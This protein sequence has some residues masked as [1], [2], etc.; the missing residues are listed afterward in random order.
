LPC[1][2]CSE[3]VGGKVRRWVFLHYFKPGQPTLN[4]LDPSCAAQ[5]V[6]SGDVTRTIHDLG[7]RVVRLDAVPFLGIEREPGKTLS[8]HFKHPLSVV[9]TDHVAMLTRKLGGW[10]FH[11]LNVPLEDLKKFTKD[12]PDLSYD[13]FTRAQVLHALLSGDAAPLRQAYGFLLDA[14]VDP[15]TLVH[16][17]QNHD[18]ITYQ[19]VELDHRKDET[20]TL[21]GKKATGKE[22]REGMLRLMRERAAGAAAP[23]NKLYRPEKDGVATTFPGFI[24]AA[25]EVRDPYNASDEEVERIKRGHLLLAVANAMQPGVFSLSSWDLVGALPVPEEDVSQWAKQGDHRW[26]NRGGVDLLGADLEAKKSALGLP[27][28][29][30]L[31]G[32]IPRQIEDA[33]SFVSQLA[34]LLAAR[35][36]FRIAEG[37]LLAAPEVKNQGVCVLVMKLP[38]RGVAVTGLN[39]GRSEVTESVELKAGEDGKRSGWVF[40][41]VLSGRD[42]GKADDEG[43]LKMTLPPLAGVTW[44]G[45]PN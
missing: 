38:D 43:R 34:R 25:M 32:P 30:A 2:D 27:R 8:K 28:A 41:D 6:V 37:E 10:S 33:E 40:V 13:F 36:K 12:G 5:R 35:K 39:F 24:A 9:G 14:G 19:L 3:C 1:G 18:E 23:H 15:G 11:E 29:K 31:Y 7:A 17:L 26:V 42:A 20:F 44:V 22:I 4:W 16:D 45:R 21:N